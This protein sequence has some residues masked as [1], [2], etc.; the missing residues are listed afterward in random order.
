MSVAKKPLVISVSRA[1]RPV[2]PWIRSMVSA[3]VS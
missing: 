3:S 1:P 2:Q